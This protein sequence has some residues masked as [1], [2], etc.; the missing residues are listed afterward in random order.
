VSRGGDALPDYQL[1][2]QFGQARTR[3]DVAGGAALY[4]R[5]ERAGATALAAWT[6]A[7]RMALGAPAGGDVAVV[8]VVALPGI[9]RPF[10]AAVCRLLPRD[11]EAWALLD[12][13]R[14]LDALGAGGATCSVALVA[15]DGRVVSCAA[16]G[17]PTADA[18]TRL[19]AEARAVAAGQQ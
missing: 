6:R 11:P 1:H 12:W 18:V 7:L 3:R 16:A 2:D 10:R 5:A 15:P 9:P 4:V 13:D 14:A 19:V 8:P 17:D